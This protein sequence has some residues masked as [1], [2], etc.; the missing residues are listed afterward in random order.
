MLG[1]DGSLTPLIKLALEAALDGEMDAHLAAEKELSSSARRNG[2]SSKRLQ[3]TAGAFEL[4]TPG[5]R[6]GD[7]EPEIVRKRQTVLTDELDGK[8]LGLFSLGMSYSDITS[9]LKELYGIETSPATISKV[10]DK[11]LPIIDEWRSQ[12][13]A[14]VYTIIAFLFKALFI[15]MIFLIL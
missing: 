13:L 1:S 8:I 3:T 5:D 7:F 6:D 4:L 12:P 10:T 2:K 14:S 15:I 11:L 9:H